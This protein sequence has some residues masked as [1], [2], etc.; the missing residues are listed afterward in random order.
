VIVG[1]IASLQALDSLINTYFLMI[2]IS[3]TVMTFVALNSFIVSLH[4][5]LCISPIG[6]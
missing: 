5:Y 3:E 6:V 4:I 2:S 1:F